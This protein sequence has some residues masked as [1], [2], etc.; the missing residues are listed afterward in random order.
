[1]K[2]E[3]DIKKYQQQF[4]RLIQK[5]ERHSHHKSMH[6]TAGELGQPAK[7][8]SLITYNSRNRTES[9]SIV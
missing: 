9:Q 1:M 5:P 7:K 3:L 4:S 6:Q 2:N 8:T